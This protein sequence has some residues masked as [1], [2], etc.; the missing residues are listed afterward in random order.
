MSWIHK[1]YET[2][3]A[4]QGNSRLNGEE[5]L[6]PVGHTQQKGHV[7]VVLNAEGD[8]LSAS[9]MEDAPLI[10]LPAT[11]SSAG[12]TSG[13]APHPLI[14]KIQYCAKD[15]PAFGGIKPSYFSSY[16][17]LLQAWCDSPHAHAKAASVLK[18]VARGRL[19]QDLVASGILHVDSRNVL[20]TS[21]DEVSPAPAIFRLLTKKKDPN[22][23]VTQ[24]QGDVLVCWSVE[25]PGDVEAKT[26]KDKGLQE[27]W[28][29]FE[30]ANV[31]MR[32][33]CYVSG[34]NSAL[35]EQ[36]PARLRNAG[37]KAKLISS[38]DT[39]GFTFRG[40]F[41]DGEQVVAVG[42][43]VSQKAHSAL[44]W[45]I[46]RQG[47]RRGT[48][49][50][51][52]WAVS[53]KEIPAP[54]G[55]PDDWISW[56]DDAP[57]EA[58]ATPAE[59]APNHSR[60]LGQIYARR[61]NK[62]MSGYG[63]IDTPTE[64]I[65]VMGL[66][67]ATTGRM[68]ITY[69]RELK[70]SEFLERLRQWHTAMA[71]PQRFTRKEPNDKGKAKPAT[72]WIAAAP[73]PDSIAEAAHGRR[74]DDKLRKATV[75]RLVPC[76]IE[77][78]PLPRDLMESCIRRAAHR[79][80]QENWEWQQ[81]LGIACAL[82]KGYFATHPDPHQRR[83][84]DMTLENTRTSRDYLF[85]RLLAIA[86]NIEQ[87][88]LYYAG[89]K[90]PTNAERLMQHFADRPF[91]AWRTLELALDPYLKRLHSRAP[92]LLKIRKDLLDD[93]LGLFHHDD[94]TRDERLS[95]EFLLGY[96]CQRLDLRHKP[97]AE[98]TPDAEGDTE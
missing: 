55:G 1:L 79:S 52:A 51:V 94:F 15:Y 14:E 45:L 33:L 63:E 40:R 72:T 49:A 8:F 83:S 86:E 7:H 93:V 37:D 23:S 78:R 20:L 56:D 4:A 31:A 50:Y 44:R 90:R 84:Y 3:E 76:I 12:R 43:D 81:A 82:F 2:Y 21:W 75:E 29:D 61:L 69:Y 64:D 27:S 53:G 74:L 70:G 59:T 58:L 19:V 96:H 48:L 57:N 25:I 35:A 38:N 13:E 60:D 16:I 98:A 47:Y 54:F 32:G 22:G 41:T 80:G 9:V 71:W 42:H 24:D 73:A 28:V 67:S 87:Q 65:I 88:A 18:Y 26:W 36:H 11:Q 97:S 89:E 6:Y 91:S 46:G 17:S 95:G 30:T 68:A 66:D 62:Y 77:G 92:G 34:E 10:T 5:A 39:N 85:G